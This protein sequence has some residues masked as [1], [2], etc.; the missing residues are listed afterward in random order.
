MATPGFPVLRPFVLTVPLVG[1]RY[2]VD[3]GRFVKLSYSP[4]PFN[5]FI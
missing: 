3:P 5:G 2:G 4:E 1:T